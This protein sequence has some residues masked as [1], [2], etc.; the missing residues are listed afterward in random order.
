M[1]RDRT[2]PDQLV[3]IPETL[4]EPAYLIPYGLYQDFI[5]MPAIERLK[6]IKD[7]TLRTLKMRQF[8]VY[9]LTEESEQKIEDRIAE[10]DLTRKME[11]LDETIKIMERKIDLYEPTPIVEY[12]P[13]TVGNLKV[14]KDLTDK[15]IMD[16][17]SGDVPVIAGFDVLGTVEP[18]IGYARLA[19]II[20]LIYLGF[21]YK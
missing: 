8:Q 3:T 9:A 7:P 11:K 10:D 14:K 6:Y 17:V 20:A 18:A 21:K 12:S 16:S 19:V 2:P 13:P 4:L 1:S 15:N 5:K